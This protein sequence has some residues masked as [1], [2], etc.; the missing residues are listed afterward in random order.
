MKETIKMTS[1]ENYNMTERKITF[2]LG[3][4]DSGYYKDNKKRCLVTVEFSYRIP[5]NDQNYIALS[6]N[7][8]NASK[9]DL[10]VFGQCLDKLISEDIS[11]Q[12]TADAREILKRLHA[13][14]NEYH[15][16]KPT[17]E[18]DELY[19]ELFELGMKPEVSAKNILKILD[20]KVK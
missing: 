20:A 17:S 1:W 6:G 9:S 15:L 2:E 11:S 19:D 5:K 12:L 16:S 18:I 8:W 13:I 14:W 10:L 3:K 4:V 7:I